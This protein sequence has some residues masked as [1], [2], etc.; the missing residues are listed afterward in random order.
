[1]VI[2]T[3]GEKGRLKGKLAK[4][5]FAPRCVGGLEPHSDQSASEGAQMG[6][7]RT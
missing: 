1:M 3:L 4:H 5:S 2:V 7:L 6:E